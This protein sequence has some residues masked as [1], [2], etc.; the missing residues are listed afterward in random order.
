MTEKQEHPP[1]TERKP[2]KKQ[3]SSDGDKNEVEMLARN[4]L[5]SY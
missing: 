4:D 1:A 5:F 2:N 3:Y